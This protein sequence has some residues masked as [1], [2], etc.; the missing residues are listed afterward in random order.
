MAL[1]ELELKRC[2][3]E[4]QSFLERRRPPPH[5]RSEVDFGYRIVGHSV[6][7]F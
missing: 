2:E 5:I 7:H 6:E 1:T 4:L 3:K